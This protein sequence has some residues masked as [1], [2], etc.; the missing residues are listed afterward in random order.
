MQQD[1]NPDRFSQYLSLEVGK[2]MAVLTG[3]P[4]IR[5]IPHFQKERRSGC[6]S[7]GEG[8]LL[9]LDRKFPIFSHFFGP[10]RSLV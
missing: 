8:F 5:L 7:R 3:D 10:L 6:L 4:G 9:A 1:I 2:V